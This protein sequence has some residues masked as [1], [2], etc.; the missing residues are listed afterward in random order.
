[1]ENKGIEISS[2]DLSNNEIKISYQNN[3]IETLPNNHSTYQLFYDSW[4]VSNPPFITDRFKIQIK[5]ITMCCINHKQSCEDCLDNFFKPGNE[6]T[7]KEF[8][9]YMRKRSEIIPL[10]RVKWTTQKQG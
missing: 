8:L 3:A 1:M 6:K 9:T 4:I 10:E 2:I 5:D 7:V